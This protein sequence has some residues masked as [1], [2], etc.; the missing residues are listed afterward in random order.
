[1]SITV[2]CTPPHRRNYRGA[3]AG[4]HRSV[5]VYYEATGSALTGSR[6]PGS[7][8]SSLHTRPKKQTSS[9][10][11]ELRLATK[12]EKCVVQIRTIL[13]IKDHRTRTV[14][15]DGGPPNHLQTV[16]RRRQRSRQMDVDL[17]G[18]LAQVCPGMV[19][20]LLVNLLILPPLAIGTA[21]DQLTSFRGT[22]TT[23]LSDINSGFLRPPRALLM[24]SHAL[25][26]RDYLRRMRDRARTQWW[27][28]QFFDVRDFVE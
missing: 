3:H 14:L 8:K 23:H 19:V 28:R 16:S 25:S 7:A 21:V 6:E 20:G 26:L 11:D 24:T 5:P 27:V 22:L 1:M 9:P 2:P 13:G 18:Y 15:P 10:N 12:R 17:G 4:D